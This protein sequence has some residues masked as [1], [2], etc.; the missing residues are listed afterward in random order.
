[1]CVARLPEF[2][3]VWVGL[4]TGYVGQ[5]KGLQTIVLSF[6]T[7]HTSSGG[8]E[9]CTD[10]MTNAERVSDAWFCLSVLL[11][12]EIKVEQKCVFRKDH[13]KNQ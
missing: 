3:Q 1:V 10:L 12:F 9:E 5:C 7:S 11:W 13:K 8:R 6:K 4:Q 2:L